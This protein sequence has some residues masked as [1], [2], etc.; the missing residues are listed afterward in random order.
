M[1][2]KLASQRLNIHM[3]YKSKE[4]FKGEYANGQKWR[5]N[6]HTDGGR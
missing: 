6:N 4:I 5:E 1:S 2:K 3:D